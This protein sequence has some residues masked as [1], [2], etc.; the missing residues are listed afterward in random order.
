M[1]KLNGLALDIAEVSERFR[2]YSQIDAL[3]IGVRGMPKDADT[4]RLSRVLRM[5]HKR[6]TYGRADQERNELAPPHRLPLSWEEPS[7]CN[8]EDYSGNPKT[9]LDVGR[10]AASQH[11]H[12]K[13]RCRSGTFGSSRRHLVT[14]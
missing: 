3:F 6:P 2:H 14:R 9:Q 1:L 11:S 8:L 5:R 12:G 13:G 10:D 7:R 4:R